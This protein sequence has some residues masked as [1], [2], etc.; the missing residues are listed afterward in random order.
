MSVAGRA[1]APFLPEAEAQDPRAPGPF[2]F[3]DPNWV[4]EILTDAGFADIE[5]ESI[6]PDLRVG[7]TVEEAL[8]F[9]SRIGPLSRVL[10]ELDEATQAEAN[11][12]AHA[13]LSDYL[14][15]DGVVLRSAAWLVCAGNAA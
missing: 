13:A 9:Q 11:A 3:A 10:A 6:T 5:I 2:A 15:D 12:A 7:A 1:I 8:Q 14:T 4:R